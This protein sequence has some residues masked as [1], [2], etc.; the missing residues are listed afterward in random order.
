M[1]TKTATDT[2]KAGILVRI[3]KDRAGKAEGVE[4]QE[5]DCRRYCENRG[6]DVVEVYVEN[7]VSASRF[8][9][10]PRHEFN[11]CLEDAR[12]GAIDAIV[13]WK[14]D[15][16]TRRGLR[17]MGEIIDAAQIVA[18]A[19]EGIDTL[20]QAGELVFGV[21]ASIAKAE[22]ENISMRTKRKHEQLARDGKPTGGPRGFGISCT[23]L[24]GC[25]LSGCAHDGITHV[26]EEAEAIRDAAKRILAGES[27]YSIARSWNEAGLTTATGGAWQARK[28]KDLL[29]QPRIAGLREHRGEIVGEA[30]WEPIIDRETWERLKVR[31]DRDRVG[32]A[33][34]RSYLLGADLLRCGCGAPMKS[35]PIKGVRGYLCTAGPGKCARR[36]QADPVEEIVKGALFERLDRPA[37][38]RATETQP[39]EDEEGNL[40]SQIAEAESR[41]ESLGELFASGKI[42][43][44]TL[45]AGT[46]AA[47][48]EIEDARRKLSKLQKMTAAAPYLGRGGVLRET[49]ASLPVGAQAAIVRE[50]FAYVEVG[51]H[52][53]GNRFNPERVSFEFRV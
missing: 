47:E 31:L 11:R 17:E 49:W 39:D 45:L 1:A 4:R 21:L 50:V 28:L 46:R 40:L 24:K 43:Q 10:K 44:K 9:T 22:A 2:I 19:S 32:V 53:G 35:N 38:A 51:P 52:T 23:N 14:A 8:G 29:R 48:V 37:L 33:R 25:T 6:W 34:P 13:I 3:S 15:R 12:S 7:D 26:P 20:N 16:S 42:P 27:A 5:E 36:I 41:L 30:V 18:S